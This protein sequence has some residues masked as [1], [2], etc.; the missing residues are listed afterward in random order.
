[1]PHLPF[2]NSSSPRPQI[3]VR[4]FQD[5][6]GG[7]VAAGSSS[8]RRSERASGRPLTPYSLL[9]G[10]R[11]AF[12]RPSFYFQK[13]WRP[14]ETHGVR[15]N[16]PEG[17]HKAAPPFPGLASAA[18]VPWRVPFSPCP[19]GLRRAQAASFPVLLRS[20]HGEH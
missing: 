2:P 14:A 4:H 15:R 17:L 19:A 12:R 10:P 9:L 20:I 18:E 11:E 3:K 8:S 13:H 1:M 5:D 6:P 16:R 7:R